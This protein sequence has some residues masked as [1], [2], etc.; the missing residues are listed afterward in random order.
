MVQAASF[1]MLVYSGCLTARQIVNII[2]AVGNAE[3]I[4][5]LRLA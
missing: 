4:V 3:D 1:A 5:S 2:K